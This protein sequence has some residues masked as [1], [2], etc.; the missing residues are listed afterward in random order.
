MKE[1]MKAFTPSTR[2]LCAALLVSALATV[3]AQVPPKPPAPPAQPA[4][5]IQDL[6]E[7]A[8][9][10]Q[11]QVQHQV[12]N[13]LAQAGAA[14]AEAHRALA[15][16][17]SDVH[18]LGGSKAGRV[19]IIPAA[20][21]EPETIAQ[22]EEDLSVMG[23]LIEKS[24]DSKDRKPKAMGLD[25]LTFVGPA[26]AQ[27]LYVGGHGAIFTLR[28]RFPLSAPPTQTAKDETADETDSTWEE[29]RREVF[30]PSGLERNV[31]GAFKELERNFK[32]EEEYDSEKVERLKNSI[33]DSMKHAARIR[34]L[35]ADERV[36]VVITSGS[37]GTFEARVG[38]G[39]GR[40]GGSARVEEVREKTRLDSV[41]T[42]QAKKSDV[43]AFA[44][45]SLDS[46]A[47]RKKV[48]IMSY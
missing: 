20:E 39:Y 21:P 48:T 15:R 6:H 2:S 43:D 19:L 29:A 16:V 1:H 30:G 41:L 13:Q 10:T 42:I 18:W 40:S 26:G 37:G 7:F 35:A 45:G 8:A 3:N 22:L 32:D 36:T 25:V 4:K 12:A 9:Q 17:K 5:E 24:V 14:Q 46:D 31:F 11:H 34:H 28:V 38:R 47:F 33:I 23:R 44:K 27:H